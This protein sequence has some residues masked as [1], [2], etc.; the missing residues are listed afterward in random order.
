M[1][2]LLLRSTLR[3]ALKGFMTVFETS[4]V[5]AA[6]SD[7]VE[8]ALAGREDE[9]A[10]RSKLAEGAS[11]RFGFDSI[12]LISIGLKTDDGRIEPLDAIFADGHAFAGRRVV[13]VCFELAGNGESH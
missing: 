10:I 11:L 3:A 7:F 13:D 8:R 2:R 1:S 5:L 9:A 4:S 12:G 6:I